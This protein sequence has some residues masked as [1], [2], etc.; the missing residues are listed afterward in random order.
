VV[1]E[2]VRA[3]QHLSYSS[4][5]SARPIILIHPS[6]VQCAK[7]TLFPLTPPTCRYA[8]Q[9]KLDFGPDTHPD[10]I[11]ILSPTSFQNIWVWP[12]AHQV[13]VLGR[14]VQQVILKC[15]P[16]WFGLTTKLCWFAC[17]VCCVYICFYILGHGARGHGST[18]R[19][20]YINTRSQKQ[21][22]L[23]CQ[24]LIYLLITLLLWLLFY[25]HMT[26]LMCAAYTPVCSHSVFSWN[27]VNLQ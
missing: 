9:Q 18:L 8:Y 25:C 19:K 11:P 7:L 5:C 14:M 13:S 17:L 6:T 3:Y 10:I 27:M 24:P 21:A 26:V 23:L 16:F 1:F 15:F 22:L 20:M 12:N 2:T 4:H